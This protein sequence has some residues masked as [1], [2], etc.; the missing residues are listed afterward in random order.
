MRTTMPPSNPWAA[1]SGSAQSN[2]CQI[3]FSE[4][5]CRQAQKAAMRMSGE[6]MADA[7]KRWLNSI[8]ASIFGGG[9]KRP[10]QVGQSGQPSPEPVTRTMPP[11]TMTTK[12]RIRMFSPI[13]TCT[14]RIGPSIAP[15]SAH[16]A[17]PRAN[18]TVNRIGMVHP[19]TARLSNFGKP[20]KPRGPPIPSIGPARPLSPHP[21][22]V[23]AISSE[24][25]P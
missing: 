19:P 24:E 14:A 22:N 3:S 11:I 10:K 23:A 15:A 6:V 1:N 16:S 25:P 7:Q 2:G 20:P 9:S 17:A 18:T 21:R 12:A 4:R 13:P 5:N 8:W